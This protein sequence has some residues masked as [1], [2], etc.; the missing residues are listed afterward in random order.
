MSDFSEAFA[1][2]KRAVQPDVEPVLTYGDGVTPDPESEVDA[3]ILA[4][5]RAAVWSADLEVKYGDVVVPTVGNG[6]KYKVTVA[7]TLGST[8]PSSWPGYDYGSVESGTVTM[9]EDGYFRG[10][11]YDVR[12]AT[13]K[14][15]L[16]KRA[17]ANEYTGA[18]EQRIAESLD[19]GIARYRPV[20]IA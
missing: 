11:V 3:I 8:E 10:G 6:R 2:V 1:E 15:F 13:Y 12:M 7:G 4:S 18:E 20:G 5:T 14:C 19:K 17:K 16:L 9:V